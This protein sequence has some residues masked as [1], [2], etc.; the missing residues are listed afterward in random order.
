MGIFEFL[1]NRGF[2]EQTTNKEAIIEKLNNEKITFYI[3]VDPT[4]DSL[5]VGHFMFLMIA[6]HLQKAGHRPIIIVGGGT[7]N[8]GDPSGRTDMR[9]MLTKEQLEYNI[10][11]I[12]KQLSRFL[13]F[14]GENAAKIINNG[15]WL[16]D[17]KYIDF[18]KEVGV[19]FNVNKMLS[20]ECYKTR[21]NSGLTFFEL[22]YMLMQAYD[23]MKLYQDEN[24]I[25]QI[26]GNDQWSNLIAGVNLT[27]KVLGQEIFGMT[28]KLLTKKDGTKM[29][30]T[31]G[32]ALWLDKEKL[33][34]YEFYQYFRNVDDEDILTLF[35]TL[36][37]LSDEEIVKQMKNENIN[38]VKSILAFEITKIIHGEEEAKNAEETS[39]AVFNG[40]N[41]I[42]NLPE[43]ENEGE[44]RIL[45]ALVY[46]KLASS[47]SDA[48]KLINQEAVS[49]N[50]EIV[51][52]INLI[53]S[54]KENIIRKGKKYI[55]LIIR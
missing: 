39:K 9:K 34:A 4:A 49:L 21:L 52:D 26:G 15:D 1:E 14:E 38:E 28:I 18:M 17:L 55:K 5:H 16:L 11:Q 35:K 2:I 48:K 24:C 45:E 23:F 43:F 22:G 44:I 27:R 13:S 7:A 42:M 51:K 31:A 32:G 54:D 6:S 19:N 41:A 20:A 3:G 10:S 30:K 46:T 12:K 37:F 47:N 25:L 36:T 29:G 8:I 40:K 33:T 53:V 50:N